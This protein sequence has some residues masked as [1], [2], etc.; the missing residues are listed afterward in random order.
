MDGASGV[1]S[2][3]TISVCVRERPSGPLSFRETMH[4]HD[5]IVADMTQGDR[6][7]RGHFRVHRRA[8]HAGALVMS[9]SR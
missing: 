9:R 7:M 8:N 4:T 1:L 2:L 5:M 3:E 6:G